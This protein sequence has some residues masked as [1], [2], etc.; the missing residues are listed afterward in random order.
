MLLSTLKI[1]IPLEE[2]DKIQKVLSQVTS[3]IRLKSGC[4]HAAAYQDFEN[5]NNIMLYE[6]WDTKE[7]L[8]RHLSSTHYKKILALI[9]LSITP[10]DIKFHSV[11]KVQ[12]MELIEALRK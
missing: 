12:G 9:E 5:S 6:I 11:S 4:T 3:L 1:K 10:P 2:K 8:H 7:S